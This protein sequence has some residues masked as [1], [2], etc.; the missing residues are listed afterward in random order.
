VAG[1]AIS[2]VCFL[3][4]LL[5]CTSAYADVRLL[6]GDPL[7]KF[8]TR[9]VIR[10]QITQ[11]DF[12]FFSSHAKEFESRALRVFLNSPGG[13]VDA[14]MKI[15]RI[16]RSVWGET[17]INNPA[18]H[19][20]SS[21]AL[22]FIAGV[23]RYNFGEL[24]LHRPYFGSAPLTREQIEKQMPIIRNV[25]KEYVEE[26]GITASFFERVFNTDPSEIDILRGD[27]SDKI[28][29]DT[30][31]TFDEVRTSLG[32]RHYGLTT[33]EYRKRLSLRK[34]CGNRSSS[35]TDCD[36][37]TIWG[38]PPATYR[39]RSAKAEAS[40]DYSDSEEQLLNAIP[41]RDRISHPI[42]IHRDNC[43]VSTMRGLPSWDETTPSPPQGG[44]GLPPGFRVEKLLAP[45]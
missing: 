3:I 41:R 28:V 14:A 16:I 15:G 13:D 43:W 25:L 11:Q 34:S 6:T 12:A 32:A 7:D 2:R 35:D 39:S 8:L 31:P 19:C 4:G 36:E 17:Y 30:D 27:D 29:P 45:K 40:C 5:F 38:L 22:I 10:G 37:A 44:R 33:S 20:Y 23:K 18:A 24:G 26:M 21:C 42:A 1:R 9:I